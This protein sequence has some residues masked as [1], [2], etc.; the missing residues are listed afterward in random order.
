MARRALPL[1]LLLPLVLSAAHAA[2]PSRAAAAA[3]ADD[4][5]AAYSPAALADRV[6]PAALPG[7][8]PPR[9]PL[10][11]PLFA[12]YVRVDPSGPPDGSTTAA[13]ASASGGGG[14]DHPERARALYYVLA[15]SADAPDAPCCLV[16]WLNGGPGCS[17]V[18]GG[19][20]SE[21]GP[22]FP[23]RLP[24]E[25]APSSLPSSNAANVTNATTTTTNAAAAAPRFALDPNPH[26]WNRGGANASVVFLESPAY[27]GFSYGNSTA[28][29]AVGDVRAAQDAATFLRRFVERFPKY[30]GVPLYLSGES[31]AGHY[32]PTL[33]AEVLRVNRAV[34][35]GAG[36]GADGGGGADADFLAVAAPATALPLAGFAVGNPWTD[37][38]TDNLGALD[39]WY[40][41]AMISAEAH[42]EVKGACDMASA[43]PLALRSAKR[44]FFFRAGRAGAAA[45]GG[46]ESNDEAACDDALDRAMREMGRINIYSVYKPVCREPGAAYEGMDEEEADGP[47][48][49]GDGGPHAEDDMAAAAA[50]GRRVAAPASAATRRRPPRSPMA[51]QPART[52]SEGVGGGDRP[53]PAPG[54]RDRKRRYDP[55]I[56]D[57]V[58]AFLNDPDVQKALHADPALGAI[59]GGSGGGG[60]AQGGG[61]QGKNATWSD[62]TDRI[63]YSRADLLSSMLPLYARLTG[64]RGVD[65]GPDGE[66]EP[67]GAGGK[68]AAE[69]LA[70][71]KAGTATREAAVRA[72]WLRAAAAS[73][74]RMW[75]YSGDTDGIVPVLGTRRWVE[76]MGL[77]VA[78]GW[79]AWTDAE[80]QV[81]GRRV[82][83]SSPAAA[84]AAGGNGT[85]AIGPFPS[86]SF[87]TVRGAGHMC[88][89]DAPQRSQ[90]LFSDFL[91]EGRAQEGAAEEAGGAANAAAAAAASQQV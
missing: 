21:Q 38:P 44:A 59:P 87:V 12:G 64:A 70:A 67:G 24:P 1:A 45:G 40:A 52:S 29:A 86:L 53:P 7:T 49:W 77:P 81:G 61:G 84:A 22:F 43:G 18:G 34:A 19:L 91:S 65:E 2:S 75:V 50:A 71:A 78:E 85:A 83:Y 80:G 56:G 58:E 30:R 15:E 62:C 10:D 79:R 23:R 82:D 60:G 8:A 39:F 55:C 88:P 57:E 89:Y 73:S 41:H 42:A 14:D 72:A 68:W 47:A 35:A 27:V 36:A 33:A 3:A 26:A 16:L 74:L 51:T 48:A 28:D 54:G 5:D 25:P 66:E 11:F 90:Q 4:D 69:A 31:Y 76:G 6:D 37:A 46:G 63:D 20:L 17:S 13:A 9:R 32:V